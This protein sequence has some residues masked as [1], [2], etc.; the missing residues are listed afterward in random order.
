MFSK[1]KRICRVLRQPLDWLG[2]WLGLTLLPPLSLNCILTLSR[3]IADCGYF[4]D[5]G[6]K[7]IARANLRLMFGTR[8]TP[9]RENALIRR[10]YRN[11]ARVLV[12]VFWMSRNTRARIDSLVSFDPDVLKTFLGNQPAITVSAHLGNWEILSQACVANGAPMISVIKQIGSPAMTQY[13]IRARSTIGQKLVPAEGALRPLLSALRHGVSLGLLVDQYTPVSEGGTWVKFFGVLVGISM[14]PAALA[15]K[16]KT[17]IIFAWS[18]PLKDGR[19]RI[20]P[21]QVFFPDPE[22]TD[23]ERTQQLANAFE[24][25]IRRHPSLWCLNYRRWRQILPGEDPSRYPF[26]ARPE[27]PENSRTPASA[28]SAQTTA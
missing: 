19:Y 1:I 2:I 12:N 16:T 14:A 24:R 9:A 3:W 7:A 5:R 25:V 13:L 6:G 20:E 15:R 23:A 10:S 11:M 26:Y 4:F 21:G 18:R 8:M 17:P 28:T 22:V 27:P